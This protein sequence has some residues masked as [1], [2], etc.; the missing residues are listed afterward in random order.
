MCYYAG[1]YINYAL[2]FMAFLFSLIS[3]GIPNADSSLITMNH[4]PYPNIEKYTLHKYSL[5][6]THLLKV[7]SKHLHSH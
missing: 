2:I 6:A 1:Q 3:P 4:T 7:I 5:K